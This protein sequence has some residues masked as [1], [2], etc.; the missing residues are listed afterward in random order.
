M[1]SNRI[2]ADYEFFMKW[3]LSLQL[4]PAV[5]DLLTGVTIHRARMKHIEMD[6]RVT[7]GKVGQFLHFIL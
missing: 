1:L 5:G 7:S 3:Q 6:G 4:I 2:T